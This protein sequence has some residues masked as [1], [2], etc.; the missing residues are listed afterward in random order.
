MP[1]TAARV[2]FLKNCHLFKGI[3]DGDLAT[4]VE[5]MTEQN[6]DLAQ[7][8]FHQGAPAD[9]MYFIYRG[10]AEISQEIPQP[11]KKEKRK[12]V[13]AELTA[14]DYFGEEGPIT[15][16]KR[17]ATVTAQPGTLLLRWSAPDMKAA[18]RKYANMRLT[19]DVAISSRRLAR[20]SN[21]DWLQKNEIIYYAA[22][23]HVL[24]LYTMLLGPLGVALLGLLSLSVYA[25]V[26]MVSVLMIPLAILA[27]AMLWGVWN[28][29]DWGN[30]F[31]IVTNLRVIRLEKVLF[32][33]DSR[34]EAPLETVLSHQVVTDFWGRLLGYGDLTVN[35]YTGKIRMTGIDHPNQAAALLDEYM[36]RVQSQQ[37]KLQ[38]DI[39]RK[40]IRDKIRPPA[41]PPVTPAPSTPSTP[42][43]KPPFSLRKA[44]GELF[45]LREESG[46]T[47]TYRKHWLILL[48]YWLKQIFGLALL[49]AIMILWDDISG[50]AI[51]ISIIFIFFLGFIVLLAWMLYDFLDWRNDRYQVTAD[52]VIDIY[53]KPL[54]IENRRAAPLENILSTEYNRHGILGLLFNFGTVYVVVGDVHFDFVDVVDP[55][56][57][58]QDIIRR[59]T[60]RRMRKQ[61]EEGKAERERMAQWLATYYN[62]VE[63]LRKADQGN[64]E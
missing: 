31:Y 33:Y 16:I 53:Q 15:G 59:M 55:P 21:F 58:Q 42:P 6:Y 17:V 18:L 7:E 51:P 1:D 57:V 9:A 41:P 28:Y 27:V 29:I 12:K 24:R 46:G 43:K 45:V 22:R 39:L 49:I 37:R 3:K 11:N 34:E 47:V 44:L 60:A 40:A 20:A 50:Q 35:T 32:M 4:L 5:Q 36:R 48:Y 19:F 38:D 10:G 23:R 8:V 61:E 62:V 14:G 56:Q 54:S 25:F 26:P 52:Q 30:D 64:K 2:S 13:L 63:E